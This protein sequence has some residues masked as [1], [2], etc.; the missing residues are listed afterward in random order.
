MDFFLHLV[1]KLLLSADCMCEHISNFRKKYQCSHGKESMFYQTAKID[2]LSKNDKHIVIGNHCHIRGQLL[3]YPYAGKIEIGDYCYL[4]EGSRIWSENCVT[5]GN[6]V[7]IAH[8]VDIHDSND[9]PLDYKERHQHYCDILKVGFLEKYNLCSKPI[10]IEDDA[11]IGF[12]AAIMKGVTIS[13]GAIIGAHAV[14]TKD[15][16]S[17]TVVAGNPAQIIKKLGE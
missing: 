1:N 4:G 16:P 9:H 13:K 8:N 17:Y 10:V 11:W 12:G 14:V 5:I 15:V 6:R 3:V 2:N 7:L